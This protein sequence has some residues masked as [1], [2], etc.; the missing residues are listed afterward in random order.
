MGIEVY[1][2]WLGMRLFLL[3]IYRIF[4]CYLCFQVKLRTKELSDYFQSYTT[5]DGKLGERQSILVTEVSF[6]KEHW[7]GHNDFYEQV[8]M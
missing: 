4:L 5:Y 8:S 3:I 1:Q 7:V 6:D 2:L